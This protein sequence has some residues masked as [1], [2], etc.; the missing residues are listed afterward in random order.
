MKHI[1]MSLVDNDFVVRAEED[2]VIKGGN[3]PLRKFFE[4]AREK[5]IPGETVHLEI[6]GFEKNALIFE[7]CSADDSHL[8]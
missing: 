6:E 7:I 3:D 4:Q 2:I 1:K 5:V 8:L